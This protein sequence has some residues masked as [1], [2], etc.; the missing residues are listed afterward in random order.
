VG[1]LP[2]GGLC[3]REFNEKSEKFKGALLLKGAFPAGGVWVIVFLLKRGI[4]WYQY[5]FEIR[6]SPFPRITKILS[7][8]LY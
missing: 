1:V 6:V 8:F 5:F 7:R 3:L 2:Q 4:Y